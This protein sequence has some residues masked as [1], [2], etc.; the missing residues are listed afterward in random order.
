MI[1][2]E[3]SAKN[4]FLPYKQF[5]IDS[6]N[7]GN[8][9]SKNFYSNRNNI[10]LASKIY[11]SKTKSSSL[12]DI[13]NKFKKMTLS[14]K[15]FFNYMNKYSKL[16]QDFTFKTPN[17]LNYP[18]KK[19]K[20]Y[21]SINNLKKLGNKNIHKDNID[22]TNNNSNNTFKNEDDESTNYI[23]FQKINFNDNNDI[24]EDNNIIKEKPYGFKFK[25][26]RIIYDE[27]KIRPKSSL[28]KNITSQI[29][30]TNLPIYNNKHK[31]NTF[32]NF[33]INKEEQIKNNT[34][35]YFYEGDFLQ[36]HSIQQ[37][38]QIK[39][40][41][42]IDNKST[43]NKNHSVIINDCET[44]IDIQI[45]YDMIKNLRAISDLSTT[46]TM[47]YNV[48]D[49]YFQVDIESLCLKFI[50][51]EQ[52]GDKDFITSNINNQKIYLP[53]RYLPIFYLLDFTTF[54]IF[55]SEIIYYNRETNLMEINKNEIKTLLNKYK[56][57]ININVINHDYSYNKR[58]IENITYYCKEYHYENL[59]D[60]IVYL[61]KLNMNNN[62]KE[63]NKKVTKD[64]GKDKNKI[65]YNKKTIRY[66]VKII[67]PIIKFHILNKKIQI[68]KY[69]NKNLLIKLLRDDFVNWEENIISDLF[70]NK[71]FRNIMNMT[72]GVRKKINFSLL[73]K[74]IFI[75]KAKHIDNLL[76]KKRFEFF[77]T[78]AIKDFSHFLYLS[79]Y[80]IFVLI[81]KKNKRKFFSSINLNIKDTIN[82]N[83]YSKYWGYINTL[84]KCM[85]VHQDSQ[86]AY[87][88]LNILEKDPQ[89]FFYLKNNEN[90]KTN[91]ENIKDL[92]KQ[93]FIKFK[94]NHDLEM[95]LVNCSL[96]EMI[97]NQ[98]RLDQRFFKIPKNLLNILLSE[99]I[100]NNTNLNSYISDY[101]EQIIFNDD[102]LNIKKEEL[103]LKRKAKI[104][105]TIKI[106]EDFASEKHKTIFSLKNLN[107]LNSFN[108][109]SNNPGTNKGLG[110]FNFFMS[111]S[112][113]RSVTNNKMN[114]G[115]LGVSWK[116]IES[117]SKNEN[118]TRKKEKKL[119][120]FHKKINKKISKTNVN[121]FSDKTKNKT[122]SNIIQVN[123][124]ENEQEK[125]IQKDQ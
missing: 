118:S 70:M 14:N 68:K 46:K 25:N 112:V 78:N 67:F 56:K 15:A 24:N 12:F 98:H 108:R 92:E 93:G 52:N 41:K 5:I 89:Q 85:K 83:K 44:N 88:D 55:L 100:K 19:N 47:N 73:S 57:F 10:P 114:L 119:T 43:K 37:E 63:E 54:K 111:S 22:N 51:Q 96:V 82:L 99:K 20:K 101:C 76:T 71:K 7:K 36:N 106:D 1:K 4:L 94:N 2:K 102:L 105:G 84:N 13:E 60:W 104:T 58:K 95:T 29:N 124:K 40:S 61:S 79:P 86:K 113:K 31:K 123:L 28:Y 23:N 80:L 121:D 8:N 115:N 18:I 110:S 34:F 39:F 91:K 26:T 122:N 17:I 30:I 53:F 81:E 65:S 50:N 64:I 42:I 116:K 74:K 72:W 62:L 27:S 87:F 120:V 117:L 9:S 21:L 109:Y 33:H 97:I 11:K 49:L 32:F 16:T 45:L 48:N 66:K 6:N 3:K 75:D 35:K 59:Y 103:E 107:K 125:Q 90:Y 77:I 69:L 38:N